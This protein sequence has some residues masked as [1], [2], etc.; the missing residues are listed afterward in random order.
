MSETSDRIHQFIT[1]YRQREGVLPSIS[2]IAAALA[3][4][5]N[6]VRAGIDVLIEAGHFVPGP[7]RTL[8]TTIQQY[9]EAVRAVPPTAPAQ[10]ASAPETDVA[11]GLYNM[12][13]T[14]TE[15]TGRPPTMHDMT[16]AMGRTA[17]AILRSLRMLEGHGLVE[18]TARPGGRQP[19]VARLRERQTA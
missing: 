7:W 16:R 14:F 17:G 11:M 3:L 4:S 6:D 13:V 5:P 18:W 10:P 9:G 19:G 2:T 1:R 12:I 15:A 8:E